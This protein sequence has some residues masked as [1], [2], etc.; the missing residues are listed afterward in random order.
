MLLAIG[1]MLSQNVKALDGVR[2][3]FVTACHV[4]HMEIFR[5][6]EGRCIANVDLSKL[7]LMGAHLFNVGRGWIPASSTIRLRVRRPANPSLHGNRIIYSRY[8]VDAMAWI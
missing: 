8:P 3:G 2:Q 6:G 4:Y 5:R 1:P 7:Y